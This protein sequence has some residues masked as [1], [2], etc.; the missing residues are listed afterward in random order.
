MQNPKIWIW[1]YEW[2]V[3]LKPSI[4]TN[5]INYT[6]SGRWKRLQNAVQI[7]LLLLQRL[8]LGEGGVLASHKK[9]K[10]WKP[11]IHFSVN[12]HNAQRGKLLSLRFSQWQRGPK[13]KFAINFAHAHIV[14]L[15]YLAS[16]AWIPAETSW[17][18]YSSSICVFLERFQTCQT[19]PYAHPRACGICGVCPGTTSRPT[20]EK[21]WNFFSHCLG[22][23]L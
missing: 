22:L 6:T 16:M 3:I 13:W 14:Q 17:C 23:Y 20:A 1:L 12:E 7:S 4:D 18:S 9:W 19:I 2:R 8:I 21:I 11:F 10:R 5:I 15:L